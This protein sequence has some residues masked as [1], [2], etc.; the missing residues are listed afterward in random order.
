M[1]FEH[2]W[3]LLLLLL[4]IAWAAWEWRFSGRRAS[5]I[6]K[7]CAFAAI[8]LALA[9]PVLTVY[10]SKVA[11]AMLADTSAS[12]SPEDLR[13]ESAFADRLERARGRHWTRIIPFARATRDSAIAERPKDGWQLHYTAGAGGR[14]TDLESAIRDGAASLPADMVPRLL[15]VSD[16]NENLG[17]A[18][19]AIWQAQQLGIPIDTVPLAGRPKPSLRLESVSIPGQ[20]FSGERF[21]VEVVLE[22]PAAAQLPR[23]ICSAEGKPIGSS[24]VQLAGRHQP[25]CCTSAGEREFGRRH[26]PGRQ[27]IRGIAGRSALR[28]CGDIAQAA[29]PV[30]LTRSAGERSS[31][32]AR[33]GIQSVRDRPRARRKTSPASSTPISSSSGQQLECG[34]DSVGSQN[35]Y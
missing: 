24:H 2:P 17:S 28:G 30:D 33:A 6:L 11:V 23:S 29:R 3:A 15:L 31:L 32:A 35:G 14:G 22:S 4:P 13:T 27:D 9:Q 20:V 16:G 8:A 19:R 21:P 34:I 10:E 26:R 25:P 5:L 18:A 7:A 12:V 1:I